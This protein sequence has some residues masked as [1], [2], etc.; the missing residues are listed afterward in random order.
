[1]QVDSTEELNARL[2]KEKRMTW[3]RTGSLALLLVA[4]AAGLSA[5]SE[6]PGTEDVDS[7]RLA[8]RNSYKQAAEEARHRRRPIILKITA[9]WCGPCRQMNQLTFTDER[10]RRRLRRDFVLLAL[11]ADEHPELVSGF[12]VESYP[13]TL[14]VSHDLKIVKRMSGFKSPGDLVS[15]LELIK[16]TDDNQ[17]AS[18][19]DD[20]DAV[21][22]LASA[23]VDHTAF[24]GFC[25]VSLLDENKLRKGETTVT[26]EYR[27]QTVCFHSEA[28]RQ[29][30]LANPERYWPANN[31]QCLVR[32]REERSTVI[33]DPRVGVV[34]RGRL[35][36]FSDRESQQ[37]FIRSPYQ[38]ADRSHET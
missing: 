9:T 31:G 18:G 33:G 32:S 37:R 22:V 6:A 3:I 12:K 11:D 8:W 1:L 25:L 30:F 14:V 21:S 38:Y 36:F 34:W 24:D 35:W 16:V 28:H 2:F 7:S 20:S 19:F 17:D 26:A 27:G 23:N 5:A 15:V 4:T 10:V 13:T 29:R